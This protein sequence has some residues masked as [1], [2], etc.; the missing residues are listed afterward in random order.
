MLHSFIDYLHVPVRRS[1]Q[2]KEHH[3]NGILVPFVGNRA[4]QRCVHRFGSVPAAVSGLLGYRR[5]RRREV[6]GERGFP[7]YVLVALV[8]VEIHAYPGRDIRVF[9]ADTRH[10]V[11]EFAYQVLKLVAHGAC[12]VAHYHQVE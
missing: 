6:G 1:V 7:H 8:A 2:H 11:L 5:Y 12:G 3:L 9:T 10:H 4:P